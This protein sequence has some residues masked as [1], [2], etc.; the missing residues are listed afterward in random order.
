MS[1]IDTVLEKIQGTRESELI[2]AVQSACERIKKEQSE[3]YNRCSFFCPEGCGSCCHD[4]EPDL[5]EA[6]ALFMAAWLIQNQKETALK[7]A[8][9]KFPFENGKTCPFHDFENPYHCS[10]YGG[11][12]V[13]CR[14]FGASSAY[15]KNRKKVWKPC[16]FYPAEKLAQHNPPLAHRQYDAA[17]TE[18][19]LGA[20]PPAM[21]DLMEQIEFTSDNTQTKLIREILPQTISRLLWVLEMCSQK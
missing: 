1:E 12:P 13:I 11:R 17:E 16:K 2:S 10:I 15:D 8:R 5:I 9:G 4:F 19:I 20:V 14:L 18:Q 3:W 7:V 6:E 21:S